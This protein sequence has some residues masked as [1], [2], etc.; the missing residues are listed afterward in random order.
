MQS[1]YQL[2][3]MGNEHPKKTSGGFDVSS[4]IWSVFIHHQQW[5]LRLFLLH[6]LPSIHLCVLWNKTSWCMFEHRRCNHKIN[7]VW[8]TMAIRIKYSYF[9][10]PHDFVLHMAM[11]LNFVP[12]LLHSICELFLIYSLLLGKPHFLHLREPERCYCVLFRADLFLSSQYRRYS[13]F[14]CC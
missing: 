6:I 13:H 3:A 1:G 2:S 4:C 9:L 5:T 11:H 7:Q 10:R 8:E 12:L 14:L